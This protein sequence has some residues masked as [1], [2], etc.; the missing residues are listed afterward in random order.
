[1]ITKILKKLRRSPLS[2]PKTD[3][4]DT[5]NTDTKAST[6]SKRYNMYSSLR[7]LSLA[8]F[9]EI[10]DTGRVYLL[11]RNYDAIQDRSSDPIP[12]EV[13]SKAWEDLYMDFQNRL[14]N[15][16]FKAIQRYQAES[17][18]YQI[19]YDMVCRMC[20]IMS[21]EYDEEFA[22][23]LSEW[24]Y[25]ISKIDDTEKYLKE[26]DRIRKRAKSI[27]IQASAASSQLE[28][29]LAK[30]KEVNKSGPK[31]GENVWLNILVRIGVNNGCHYK[32]KEISCSEFLELY[33]MALKSQKS[34]NKQ[35]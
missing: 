20:D 23:L 28:I 11:D 25:H 30:S 14:G 7:E 13:L 24:G 8:N 12:L 33:Q 35:S 26:L 9:V 3:S 19:K 34:K 2:K 22:K 16:T 27:L 32:P 5:G 18:L 21:L 1:M 4:L 6:G 15:N 10:E 31:D 29:L 17:I